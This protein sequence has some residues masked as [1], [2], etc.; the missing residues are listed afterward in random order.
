M[1]VNVDE[2]R[3]EH[4]RIMEHHATYKKRIKIID[5]LTIVFFVALL[6]ALLF[7]SQASSSN[8]SCDSVICSVSPWIVFGIVIVVAVFAGL[9]AKHKER[10]INAYRKA[11]EVLASYR[12]IS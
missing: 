10:G 1:V 12:G 5:T 9:A 8:L 3:E 6:L 2:I 7:G 4:E 11:M